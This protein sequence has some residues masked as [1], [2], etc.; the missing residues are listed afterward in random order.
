MKLLSDVSLLLVFNAKQTIYS[1]SWS[2]LVMR[3]FASLDSVTFPM[4]GTDRTDRTDA[5]FP[6]PRLPGHTPLL[7]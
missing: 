1:N 3:R 6:I 5:E 2:G 7:V 4:G